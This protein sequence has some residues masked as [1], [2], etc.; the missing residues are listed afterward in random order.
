[1]KI[2]RIVITLLTVVL[3][4]VGITGCDDFWSIDP[5]EPVQ[6]SGSSTFVVKADGEDPLDARTQVEQI[7]IYHKYRVITAENTEADY[8]LIIRY[9]YLPDNEVCRHFA[10]ILRDAA[11]QDVKRG[12]HNGEKPLQD[13]LNDFANFLRGSLFK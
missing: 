5:T 7:L 9:E 3:L 6:I 13:L 1:M 8:N 11:G 2:Q 12:S 4:A 10:F